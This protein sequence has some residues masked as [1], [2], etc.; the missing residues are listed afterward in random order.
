MQYRRVFI[1]AL[2]CAF[3][4]LSSCG[5]D[6]ANCDDTEIGRVAL[7]DG[8][9]EIVSFHRTC[10]RDTSRMTYAKV[11]KRSSRRWA[12]PD[13]FCYLM[14][15]NNYHSV[16]A[17]WLDERN[18]RISTPDLLGENDFNTRN[19][20]CQ[21]IKVAYDVRLE[22]PPPASSDDPQV[23]RDIEKI[24]ATTEQCMR[25]W[26]SEHV[27]QMVYGN[28][29]NGDQR[30]ALS[31]IFSYVWNG[32]CPLGRDT[33]ELMKRTAVSLRLEPNNWQL[34]ENQVVE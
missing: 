29:R 18:I 16:K 30:A 34:I 19:D 17:V 27:D 11:E 25:K 9:L 7:P 13:E 15:W 14:T 20:T 21:N 2:V 26:S 23:G 1:L 5:M 24:L 6:H 3:F 32:H 33:F 12:S 8:S 4:L 22:Q 10:S 31:F 28:L